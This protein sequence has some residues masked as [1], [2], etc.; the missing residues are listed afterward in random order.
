MK[1]GTL[2]I[3]RA[4]AAQ[5]AP[6]Q[7]P[8]EIGAS[9]TLNYHGYLQQEEYN[10]DLIGERGLMVYDR[11]QSSDGAVAET[12][13]H[14]TQPI[15]NAAWP[16]EHA[17]SEPLDLELAALA[18]NALFDWLEQPWLEVIDQ[19]LDYL[20]F[21]HAVFETPYKI[22]ERELE[23]EIPNEYEVDAQGRRT[24]KRVVMPSRQYATFERFAPRLQRTVIKWSVEAG[25][26]VSITQQAMT[27]SGAFEQMTIPG[28]QL[29]VFTNRKRGDD[30]AGRSL[31]RPAYKH[32]WLKELLEKI[33]VLAAIRH[34]IGVWV[35]YPPASAKDDAAIA[36]RIETIL[37]ALGAE[38]KT[39]YIVSPGPK[40]MGAGIGHDGW[41]WEIQVPAGGI[42]DFKS[43]LEY[44]RGEI[45]GS[46]LARFSELG[47]GQTGARATGDTQSQVWYDALHSTA[48][49]MCEVFNVAIK[50][51]IDLNYP[52]VE[53]YPK[54]TVA[55]IEAR[56]LQEFAD[57][58]YK[59]VQ[60]EAIKPDGTYRAA[61]RKF[62][63]MPPEDEVQEKPEPTP[64]PP[65]ENVL[66]EPK[67]GVPVEPPVPAPAKE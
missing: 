66:P 60:C 3:R 23:Y 16:I 2:E 51:L 62:V 40:A 5:E 6:P 24:P 38:E 7:A 50:R 31:L 12:L 4:A 25:K 55:N 58:H 1:I 19:A 56:N 18:E 41:T 33:G 27:D 28:E 59:L 10:S 65:I 15:L 45:K 53:R 13:G 32:W 22:I 35:A 17:G 26:L 37:E 46:V 47:H 63:D 34:G 57:A 64:A 20:P 30:F 54:L 21:G 67:P 48:K 36:D 9:G 61:V 8:K 43:L 42:P 29:I 52:G 39:P 14:I 44:H 11:M 49:Y